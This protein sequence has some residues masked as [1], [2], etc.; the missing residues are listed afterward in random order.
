LLHGNPKGLNNV[1]VPWP[2]NLTLTDIVQTLKSELGFSDSLDFAVLADQKA[3]GDGKAADLHKRLVKW[4]KGEWLESAV[5]IALNQCKDDGLFHECGMDLVAK[6]R[7]EKKN[8]NPDFQLDVVAVRGYRLFAFSCTT[9]TDKPLIKLKLF[10]AYMRARQ[11][12]GDE[13]KAAVVACCSADEARSIEAEVL[14]DLDVA[15][16]N[17]RVFG[18]NSFAGLT[19]NIRDWIADLEHIS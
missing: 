5:L 2:D 1:S 4:L 12:G 18:R 10:E 14:R 17:T 19:G 13:A 15:G 9:D 7:D 6:M 16:G 11:I 3:L 8:V